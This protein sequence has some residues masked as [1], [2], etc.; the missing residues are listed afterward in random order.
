M[1]GITMDVLERI[2]YYRKQ[3]NWTE[4]Q[5]AEKSGLT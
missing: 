3:K 4:Y 2:I 5:L 1:G